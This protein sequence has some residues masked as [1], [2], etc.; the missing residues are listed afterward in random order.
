VSLT[1]STSNSSRTAY[2]GSDFDF[3]DV[4]G[5]PPRRAS[6]HE[7]R[8]SFS[9]AAA[10]YYGV[11]GGGGG[12]GDD[13]EALSCPRVGEKPVFGEENASRRRY[14]SDNFFEDIFRGDESLSS[15][16]RKCDRGTLLLRRQVRGF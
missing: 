8:C 15:T 10:E 6:A 4:F 5:G 16:P 7:K 11:G 13:D 14:P 1:N 12:G 2:R 3:H 9:E